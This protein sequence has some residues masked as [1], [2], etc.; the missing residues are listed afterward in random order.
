MMGIFKKLDSYLNRLPKSQMVMLYLMV[1]FVGISLV[2][3]L[4]PDMI[5]KR[6][7]LEDEVT[8]LQR[9]INRSSTLRLKRA[10]ENNRKILLQ[11]KEE[12]KRLK[13]QT[14]LILSKLYSLKFAFFDEK[15]WINTLDKILNRSVVYN[16]K[17]KYV[18]NSN[19]NI[20]KQISTLVKKKKNITIEAEG[21]FADMVRYINYIESL[22]VLLRLNTLRLYGYDGK[23]NALMML[24]AYG[25]GI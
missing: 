3:N 8:T 6:D 24:D 12:F 13:A 7:L 19:T 23:V 10:L 1:L 2:Y 14:S 5:E 20:T 15:E 17:I 11:K 25:V 9:N 18:K 16:I 22:P 4:V 21:S